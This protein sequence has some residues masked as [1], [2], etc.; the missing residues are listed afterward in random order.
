MSLSIINLST[1]NVVLL[2]WLLVTNLN[3]KW[4]HKDI[5]NKK[6][7]KIDEHKFPKMSVSKHIPSVVFSVI[8]IQY[9]ILHSHVKQGHMNI[10][11]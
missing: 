6:H 3:K 9:K 2:R 7:F 8:K 10:K 4:V 1:I 11:K 5:L